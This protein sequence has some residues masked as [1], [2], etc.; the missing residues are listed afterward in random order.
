MRNKYPDE[1]RLK[2]GPG[3]DEEEEKKDEKAAGE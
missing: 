1:L 3:D 2:G